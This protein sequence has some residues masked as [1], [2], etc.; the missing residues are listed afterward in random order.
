MSVSSIEISVTNRPL[1]FLTLHAPIDLGGFLNSQQI[2]P[3]ALGDDLRSD[4]Q[5]L[6]DPGDGKL[7]HVLTVAS[8]EG[9]DSALGAA[10]PTWSA[11][12]SV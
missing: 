10:L 4:R 2:L 1:P 8:Q 11:T 9:L 5:G 6:R 3:G 7:A 12:S